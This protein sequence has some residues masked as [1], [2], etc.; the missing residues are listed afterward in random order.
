MQFASAQWSDDGILSLRN[1]RL[2]V[3]PSLLDPWPNK[4][5][6]DGLT[7]RSISAP[8]KALSS[9]STSNVG[10]DF[11]SWFDKLVQ[12]SRQPYEQLATVVQTQ[13][14]TDRAT[15][16]R[17]SARER[18]RREAPSLWLKL[19]DSVVGYGYYPQKSF[20]WVAFFV[21]LGAVVLRVTGEG[22]KNGM[23]FGLA[24]SFDMLLPIV[25]LR[26]KHYSIDL[27]GPA[28]YYF[29]VHRI[30]GWVLASFLVAGLSG[31]TK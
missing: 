29:Y 15:A 3:I 8:P 24:Y 10:E 16:I 27:A 25:R 6:L 26:E 22:P 18:E 21:I 1:S 2:D 23:P 14:D 13:G 12:Y 28:R 31:F 19:L 7:Y 20:R 17:Y 11:N 30:M 5:D 4:L 9:P